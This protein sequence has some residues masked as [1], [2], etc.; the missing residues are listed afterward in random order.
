MDRADP[1][2]ELVAKKIIE[3]AKTGER[4]PSRITGPRS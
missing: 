4:N 3:I 2:N 1:L